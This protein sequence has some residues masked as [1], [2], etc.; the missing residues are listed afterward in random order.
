MANEFLINTAICEGNINSA[1]EF[2]NIWIGYLR[3]ITKN[4]LDGGWK[5][6]T[7]FNNE[8]EQ[9]HFYKN[10]SKVADSFPEPTNN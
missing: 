9:T 8:K 3:I 2:S 6:Q 10:K 4:I 1:L 5:E 7:Q